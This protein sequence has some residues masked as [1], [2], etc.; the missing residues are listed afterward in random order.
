MSHLDYPVPKLVSY[1]WKNY[2][3]VLKSEKFK[4]ILFVKYANSAFSYLA[5][6]FP[7]LQKWGKV[8]SE[9]FITNSGHTLCHLTSFFTNWEHAKASLACS[10]VISAFEMFPSPRPKRNS[11]L[12]PLIIS[13]RK[14]QSW[15]EVIIIHS[16]RIELNLIL[17][18]A[19]KWFCS[20]KRRRISRI[21]ETKF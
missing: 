20:G 14:N 17:E 1:A 15:E 19:G 21:C 12:Q 11:L 2:I 5:Y 3:R 18:G 16:L 10:L 4:S 7:R 8:I 13:G 9:Y 6:N